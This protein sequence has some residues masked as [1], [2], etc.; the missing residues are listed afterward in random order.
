MLG[1]V[2]GASDLC[3][4]L[5]VCR[6]A[7]LYTPM[8]STG[9]GETHTQTTAFVSPRYYVLSGLNHQDKRRLCR[10]RA[11]CAG[12][13]RGAE[14]AAKMT[15]RLD[16]VVLVDMDNTLVDFDLEFGKRWAQARPQ[17]GLS[18]IKSRRHF[19]LEQNFSP[20]LKPLAIEIMSQPGFFIAFEPQKYAV[21]AV[22]E[23]EAAGLHVMLCTAPLPFQYESCVA[24]KFAWVRKWLGEEWLSRIVV[25]RDKTLVKGRVLI[26]DKPRVAGA[27]DAPEWVHVLFDQPYNREVMDRP[28]LADWR[29]WRKVVGEFVQI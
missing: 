26:D 4:R 16:K 14:Q 5:G 10:T 29:E 7:L 12:R 28:R 19:E 18:L 27:C 8:V 11:V 23:M 17:D 9:R 15:T 1:S 3:V 13:A 6:T 20:D 22:K 25:T 2:V 21:Q 24:E